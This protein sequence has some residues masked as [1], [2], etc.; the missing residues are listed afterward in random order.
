MIPQSFIQELLARVDIVDV[1][2]QHVKLRKAGANLL[3]LCPFH[4]EKSPSFTVSPTKQFYHC[5]GCG[6]HGSAVGFLMEHTGVSYVEAINDLARAAGLVVPQETGRE[7]RGAR[8]APDLF[9]VLQA[10]SDFYRLRLKDSPRAIDY[11][12]GRGLSG[13]TAARFAI[14]YAPEGWRGLQAAVADYNAPNLLTAG[15][16]IEPDRDE[17][18][19]EDE[20]SARKRYDRFRDRIMFPIRNPRGQIIGFGGRVLGAGEPKYLNSPETPLFTKGRE[21]YGLFEGR[22]AMRATNCAIVVEGYMDVV[23]LAQHG[24]GNAVATLGTATTSEHVRKLLRVVDRVVFSFDGDAAGRKAAWRALE[25]CLAHAL[26]TKRLEFLFLPPEHDPDSFVRAHGADGFAERLAAAM[27]LSDLLVRELTAQVD[28]DESEGRARLLA[29]A[30]P[31]LAQLPREGLRL[32]LV[33]RIADLARISTPEFDGFLAAGEASARRAEEG[34]RARHEPDYRGEDERPSDG[35]WSSP[36]GRGRRDGA[37]DGQSSGLGR[38]PSVGLRARAAPPDLDHRAHLLAALHPGVA[39]RVG[40][41]SFLP[42]GLARWLDALAELP[43]GSS[44]ASVCETLRGEHQALVSS[45]EAAAVTDRHQLAEMAFD[46]ALLE[47][48][49]ALSQL[50]DRRVRAE[51]QALVDQGLETPAAREEYQRLLALRARG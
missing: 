12:K 43:A 44:F 41:H 2:G 37:R 42:E 30:R 14:G 34:N 35:R 5:F 21:L 48:E 38:G 49:G 31:L 11:L 13:R 28:L 47:F 15:L 27:P 36:Q 16:V 51:L 3:G 26:D 8:A 45:L 46:D 40:D 18:Q 1:V 20:A 50:R 19:A 17:T 4:G 9:E 24:V 7:D 32:Q 33:H 29:L 10:A 6:A 39:A 23:M 22:E 25:A